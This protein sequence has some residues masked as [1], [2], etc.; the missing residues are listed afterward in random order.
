MC[1]ESPTMETMRKT[2][3]QIYTESSKV[4]IKICVKIVLIL[5]L[6]LGMATFVNTHIVRL[7]VVMGE[8]MYPTFMDKDVLLIN[9]LNHIHSRG[10]VVLIDISEKP[11]PGRYIVK[12][13][14]AVEGD[15][16]NLD[17]DNNLVYVNGK[18]ES[19]PYLNFEQ[20]DPMMALDSTQTTTYHVTAGTVF[21][22]GD[23][24]NNSID[25]RNDMLG[26]IKESDIIG[27]VFLSLHLQQYFS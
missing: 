16:V 9:Q 2:I 17:Y 7:A 20:S 26:M 11:P 1:S 12:R 3:K 6:L 15:V 25:S 5:I 21:V 24:R 18:I 13:I 4:Y 8:S 14:I 10:D 27:E 22:M 19:E 23:N